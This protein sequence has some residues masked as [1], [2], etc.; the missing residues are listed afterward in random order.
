M[1]D[2]R[3]TLGGITLA[4]LMASGQAF[5]GQAT[6]DALQAKSIPLT[7]D[8]AAAVAAAEPNA[9]PGVVAGLAVAH[10]AIAPTIVAAA[11]C[12]EPEQSSAIVQQAVSA[13][14]AQADAI[15]ALVALGCTAPDGLLGVGAGVIP[16]TGIPSGGGGGGSV[17]PN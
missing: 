5:A 11:A 6:L 12:A 7:D 8:Q 17:S 1:S 4:V 16:A 10:E 13:V 9:L 2:M 15:N 3:K 14:P